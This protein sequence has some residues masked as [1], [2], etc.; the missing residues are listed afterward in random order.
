MS[1]YARL[2][3]TPTVPLRWTPELVQSLPADGNRYE[4]IDGMLLVTPSPKLT[5]QRVLMRLTYALSPYVQRHQVGELFNVAADLQLGDQALLQPDLFVIAADNPSM[6]SWKDV[7]RLVLAVEVISRSSRRFDRREK[8]H[9]YLSHGV[10]DYWT[11]DLHEM[12]I[13]RWSLNRD[14]PDVV[15]DELI[16]QP[17]DVDEP[18]RID[19]S[20]LFV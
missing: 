11:V 10:P 13:E 16:W 6:E 4:C 8:R 14:T 2:M 20:S 9:Y 1:Q 15:T 18:C 3:A 12:A 17:A 5:H 7:S 19:V